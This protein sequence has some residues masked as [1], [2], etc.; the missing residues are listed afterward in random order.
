MKKFSEYDFLTDSILILDEKNK[1]C[2]ANLAY[3]TNFNNALKDIYILAAY[4]D[5]DI[6]VLDNSKIFE[7]NPILL[8]VKH[9]QN[10][11]CCAQNIKN[12]N[13]YEIHTKIQKN[14]KI[15]IIKNQKENTI[16]LDEKIKKLETENKKFE[17]LKLKAQSQAVKIGLLNRIYT[18]IQK[19]NELDEIINLA[20]KE[21]EQVFGA[22]KI[23][24]AQ[25]YNEN[26]K[27]ESIYPKK[28]QYAKSIIFNYNINADNI[29]EKRNIIKDFDFFKEEKNTKTTR[30]TIPI[31]ERQK[32][33]GFLCFNIPLK[34][35]LLIDEDF[36]N[37]LCSQF[38]NAILQALLLK[39]LKENQ[40]QLINSEKMATL[41]NMIA[42]VAHEINT[43]L[44]SINSNN[45]LLTKLLSKENDNK[46]YKLL[47]T[48]T[49]CDAEA[50]KRITTIV[51]SLK[52]FIRL[53][54]AK[55]QLTD[56]DK[57]MDLTLVLCQ[58]LT[59]NR[60]TIEKNYTQLQPIYTHPNMLNQVFMNLITN[61]AQSIEGKGKITISTLIK[62]NNI[63]ICVKDT[64]CGIPKENQEFIFQQGFTTKPKDQGSGLGLSISKRI[65]E[66]LGGELYFISEEQKG[67]EFFIEL[68]LIENI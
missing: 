55:K 44:G 2:Y 38:A 41:G 29:F 4:F 33:L 35:F 43:P 40:L 16:E 8:G 22:E 20:F 9:S 18:I 58:H 67:T 63:I 52:K 37:S 59:K 3:K 30:I 25:K 61:A 31:K 50:I 13:S 51:Q 15:F 10:Y 57:E 48:M 12:G 1:I 49:K 39:Q 27:I 32:L 26:Y 36:L 19:E 42:A 7:I 56:V 34:N 62:N 53:D 14:Y 60:I 66:Q 5:F 11:S 24:Y 21:L 17:E 64:G 23:F 68:P 28:Y 54:E 6:C 65:I 46:L 47:D 45:E